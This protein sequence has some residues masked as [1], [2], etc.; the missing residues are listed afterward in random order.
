M[1]SLTGK[2]EPKKLGLGLLAG[3]CLALL[4]YVSL[5]KLFAI[6]SPVFGAYSFQFDPV[7]KLFFRILLNLSSSSAS[8]ANTSGLLQ[9]AP[10]GSSAPQKE[11]IPPQED[12]TFGGRKNDDPVDPVDFPEEGPAVAGS[13]EPGLPEALVS[14]KEKEAELPSEPNP[15]K[16]SCLFLRSFS[17]ESTIKTIEGQESGTPKT[18]LPPQLLLSLGNLKLC[19]L[20]SRQILSRPH[21]LMSGRIS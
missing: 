16:E 9:N 5:A 17:C 14:K 7:L 4:T 21:L 20:Q 11:A 18:R 2:I 12:T 13:E 1:R 10:P 3:G 15:C 8:T 19:T 6:Y